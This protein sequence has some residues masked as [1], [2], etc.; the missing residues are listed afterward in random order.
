MLRGDFKRARETLHKAQRKDPD[1]K[2]VANNL[3]LL[4]DSARLGKSI[5]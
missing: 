5:E 4:D 2:F 1:N 3:R